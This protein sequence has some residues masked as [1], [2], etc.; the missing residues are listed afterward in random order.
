[1][2]QDGVADSYG[3]SS[4]K[5][6]KSVDSKVGLAGDKSGRAKLSEPHTLSSH[7]LCKSG[8]LAAR[9]KAGAE[10]QNS[11]N[12]LRTRNSQVVPVE[13]GSDWR[14]MVAKSAPPMT[15]SHGRSG[16]IPR[17]L[18]GELGMDATLGDASLPLQLTVL[19][20]AMEQGLCAG[21]GAVRARHR[22][23]LSGGALPSVS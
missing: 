7:A 17:E 2:R 4:G 5:L 1:V 21:G 18:A 13:V 11:R 15:S 22:A 10:E 20:P 9:R 14:R 19:L 23:V 12:V 16:S 3:L 8:M 6:V